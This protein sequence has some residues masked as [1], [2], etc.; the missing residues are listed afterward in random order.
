MGPASNAVR[1]GISRDDVLSSMCGGVRSASDGSES[2]VQRVKPAVIHYFRK[3]RYV[4]FF[5]TGAAFLHALYSNCAEVVW[6]SGEF[7]PRP[8]EE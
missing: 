8:T 4:P 3:R 7:Y 6:Y 5:Q 2:Y 1:S